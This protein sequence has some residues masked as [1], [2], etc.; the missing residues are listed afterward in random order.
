MEFYFITF[1]FYQLLCT[2][3]SFPVYRPTFNKYQETKLAY[4]IQYYLKLFKN[5][6]CAFNNWLASKKYLYILCVQLPFS[7]TLCIRIFICMQTT[8]IAPCC[9]TLTCL[10][11][12]TFIYIVLYSNFFH[13]FDV[14]TDWCVLLNAS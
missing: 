6:S 3:L 5:S 4:L 2:A 12:C 1:V 9:N 7:K 13:R 10:K 11:N 14:S 8:L